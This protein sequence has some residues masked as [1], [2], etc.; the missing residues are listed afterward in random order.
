MRFCSGQARAEFAFFARLR[1]ARGTTS[2]Q[3]LFLFGFHGYTMRSCSAAK[4]VNSDQCA[5]FRRRIIS[6]E[7]VQ[8]RSWK[9]CRNVAD[10]SPLTCAQ[11]PRGARSVP[12]NYRLILP[13][14]LIPNGHLPPG[15]FRISH[16]PKSQTS[17]TSRLTSHTRACSCRHVHTVRVSNV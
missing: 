6:T 5:I 10:Y 8:R 14:S 15:S 3:G 4:M 2:R 11:V 16:T 7:K 1:A 13:I 17:R 9:L 12:T